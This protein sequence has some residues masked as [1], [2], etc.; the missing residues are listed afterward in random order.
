MLA[1]SF[2][3][4]SNYFNSHMD[5]LSNASGDIKA[6]SL[7]RQRSI[8]SMLKNRG[9]RGISGAPSASRQAESIG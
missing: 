6:K 7:L 3:R 8:K 5:N 9:L 1:D 4:N 2:E